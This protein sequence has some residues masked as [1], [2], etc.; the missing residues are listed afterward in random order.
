MAVNKKAVIYHINQCHFKSRSRR[1][2]ICR[3]Q[4]ISHFEET[5]R[6]RNLKVTAL[7]FLLRY[8][9]SKH[10]EF[11]HNSNPSQNSRKSHQSTGSAKI[12][13]LY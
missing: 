7:K 9:S 6:V 13:K 1:A 3:Q 11:H 10:C 8:K 2:V 5:Q 4:S 12:S